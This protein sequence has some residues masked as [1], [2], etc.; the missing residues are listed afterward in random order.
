MVAKATSPPERAS[1]GMMWQEPPS[2]IYLEQ[3]AWRRERKMAEGWVSLGRSHFPPTGP[4]GRART[5]ERKI[6][7]DRS[8][9]LMH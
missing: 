1:W 4:R 7:E 9:R 6:K 2:C 3:E 5:K 8:V